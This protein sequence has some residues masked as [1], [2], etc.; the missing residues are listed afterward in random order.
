M[1]VGISIEEYD[2]ALRDAVAAIHGDEA[3]ARRTIG[4]HM[5]VNVFLHGQ[6]KAAPAP[7]LGVAA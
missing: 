4:R 2:L 5:A 3:A 6:A 1:S 7:T